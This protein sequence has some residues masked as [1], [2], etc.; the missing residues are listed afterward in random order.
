VGDRYLDD[1][2]G[3]KEYKDEVITAQI[4]HSGCP[5]RGLRTIP[6]P[7]ARE[8]PQRTSHDTWGARHESP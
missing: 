3:C 2:K 7:T 1:A 8:S 6:W 4:F 5:F